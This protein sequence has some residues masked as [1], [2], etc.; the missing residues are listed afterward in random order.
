MTDFFEA[1]EHMKSPKLTRTFRDAIND[2]VIQFL[3]VTNECIFNFFQR[4]NLIF[5]FQKLVKLYL[6]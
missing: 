4:Q 1:G 5:V 6:K 3:L 2:A